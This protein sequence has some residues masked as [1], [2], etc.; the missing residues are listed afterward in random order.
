[1]TAT[2]TGVVA[3]IVAMDTVEAA[4][5]GAAADTE[6]AIDNNQ[7]T[8]RA[9]YRLPHLP[10]STAIGATA[11]AMGVATIGATATAAAA[12]MA[13][14]ATGTATRRS[15]IGG[16]SLSQ[17]DAYD[18]RRDGY[19]GGGGY[20]GA[21]P[22]PPQRRESYGGGG[23]GYSGGGRCPTTASGYAAPPPPPMHAA[24]PPARRASRRVSRH[25]SRR[26]SRRVSRRA[27]GNTRPAR[28]RLPTLR[29]KSLEALGPARL[30]S[31]RTRSAAAARSRVVGRRLLLRSA[32]RAARRLCR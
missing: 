7:A 11:T 12:T 5:I 22:P 16:R 9:S 29:R 24:P 28:V 14:A 25:A 6:V 13:A 21:P 1:M 27:H 3:T 8:R 18:D 32:N 26:A 4:V 23:G 31:N 19:G 2:A 10:G 17:R 15:M 20:N 30:R